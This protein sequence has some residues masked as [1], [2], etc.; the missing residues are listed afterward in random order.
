MNRLVVLLSFFSCCLFLLPLNSLAASPKMPDGQSMNCGKSWTW[1]PWGLGGNLE[2]RHMTICT[3]RSV[4]NAL[5]SLQTVS[6]A[7]ETRYAGGAP[8]IKITVR[9]SNGQ[10]IVNDYHAV[11]ATVPCGGYEWHVEALPSIDWE[12]AELISVSASDGHSDSGCPRSGNSLRNAGY[13]IR[14]W[15]ASRGLDKEIEDKL[16]SKI[17]EFL[18]Q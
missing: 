2:I 8:W 14:D 7:K 5:I 4:S 9:N 18:R 6:H 17:R 10:I 13:K 1:E 12:K 3:N 15:F 16:E 11:V